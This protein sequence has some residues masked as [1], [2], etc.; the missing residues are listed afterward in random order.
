MPQSRESD[1]TVSAKDVTYWLG[2]CF[3][4]GLLPLLPRI[5]DPGTVTDKGGL[6]LDL[7]M[8]RGELLWSAAA[9]SITLVLQVA[10]EGCRPSWTMTP[11][12]IIPF[13]VLL[14]S[15]IG[16]VKL[17]ALTSIHATFWVSLGMY[18]VSVLSSG[19]R[20]LLLFAFPP[21]PS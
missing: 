20:L 11:F 8:S 9:I 3:I 6:N 13:V 18:L 15:V 1:Q 12:L 21:V 17:P 10:S 5:L 7:L 2:S 14:A 19:I 4:I 16:V